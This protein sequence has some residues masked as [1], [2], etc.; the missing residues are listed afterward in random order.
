MLTSAYSVRQLSRFLLQ[1]NV[2]EHTSCRL[3]SMAVSMTALQ[4]R[5]VMSFGPVILTILII[6]H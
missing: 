3:N 1:R 5:P 6:R 2:D 4:R